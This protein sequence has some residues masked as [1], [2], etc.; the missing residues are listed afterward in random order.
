MMWKLLQRESRFIGR[1]ARSQVRLVGTFLTLLVVLSA[2]RLAVGQGAAVDPAAGGAAAANQEDQR[3]PA[4]PAIEAPPEGSE[5]SLFDSLIGG[6]EEIEAESGAVAKGDQ[7]PA[8]EEVPSGQPA[9]ELIT[10]K[11]KAFATSCGLEPVFGASLEKSK[12]RSLPYAE[13]AG[14]S[15]IDRFGAANGLVWFT[16]DRVLYVSDREDHRSALLP[17]DRN[18]GE[19]VIQRLV[20][21]RRLRD[22]GDGEYGIGCNRVQFMGTPHAFV[23]GHI[24]FLKFIKEKFGIQTGAIAKT[25]SAA[26][27]ADVG[28]GGAVQESGGVEMDTG[29]QVGVQGYT[30]KG[31][32]DG[33]TP[34]V[35]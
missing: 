20:A 26:L 24:E 35:R 11:L 23:T 30:M 21:Q 22:W 8:A 4:A 19:P 34:S 3:A 10:D 29:D 27:D 33:P 28:D 5:N 32:D 13:A 1:S 9:A 6:G 7:A 14:D 12:R 18:F 31:S 15:F 17:V 16:N 2:F 25:E